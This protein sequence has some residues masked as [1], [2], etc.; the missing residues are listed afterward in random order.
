[1]GIAPPLDA[2]GASSASFA[3]SSALATVT[4]I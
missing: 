3:V 2:V 1:M 4:G